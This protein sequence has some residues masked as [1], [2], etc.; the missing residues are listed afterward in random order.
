MGAF[1]S[2]SGRAAIG[3]DFVWG[4]PLCAAA[5]SSSVSAGDAAGEKEKWHVMQGEDPRV[6]GARVPK[7][8]WT[9][10]LIFL[11]CL[12]RYNSY[13]IKFAH[14]QGTL[15]CLAVRLQTCGAVA[16]PIPERFITLTAPA[17]P[18]L[19]SLSLRISL[20]WVFNISESSSVWSLASGFLHSACCLGSSVWL[21]VSG[22]RFCCCCWQN[23][24]PPYGHTAACA[25]VLLWASIWAVSASFGY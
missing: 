24:V 20:F 4:P 15:Q 21:Q 16:R 9:Q 7:Q 10:T 13:T 2:V 19:I 3:L 8:R 14:F 12:L 22:V 6:P 18:P 23:T 1:C 25:S 17:Q 11:L 5:C